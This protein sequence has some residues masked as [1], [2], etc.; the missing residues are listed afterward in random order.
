[1]QSNFGLIDRPYDTDAEFDPTGSKPRWVRFQHWVRA[2]NARES[3]GSSR[4]MYKVLFLGRHGQGE[5]NVAEAYYGTDAWDVCMSWKRD[6]KG[7]GVELIMGQCYWSL[8]E[9]NET[10]TWA[11]ARLTETGR[12]QARA[13]HEAW[14]TEIDRGM[15]LA[16]SFYVSPLNRCL[17]TAWITFHELVW[18]A[19]APVVMEVFSVV[20]DIWGWGRC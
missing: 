4:T 19:F 5:H 16:E 8:R 1:M 9:G 6:T 3:R 12:A 11:D 13:A 17:E 15:P 18:D 20:H 2:L 7:Q 14:R 10:S